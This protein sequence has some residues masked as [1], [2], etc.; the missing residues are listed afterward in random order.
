MMTR[1]TEM[2][3]KMLKRKEKQPKALGIDAPS[4]RFL[5]LPAELRNLI[6]DYCIY[7][8][9]STISIYNSI[10]GHDLGSAVLSPSIFRI[11]PQIRNEAL[12]YLSSN[13][14]IEL[15][16]ITAALSFFRHI[17]PAVSDLKNVKVSAL[18]DHVLH[19]DGEQFLQFLQQ[20]K[21]LQIFCLAALGMW[22]NTYR[23]EGCNLLRALE[24]DSP[25]LMTLSSIA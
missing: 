21:S 19:G 10:S 20:A 25:S 2:L 16:G 15:H 1:R 22:W 23:D 9:L 6:Y 18:S 5:Q 7:H 3:R 4:S 24:K 17:G 12:S 11:S 8:E 14:H 13:K